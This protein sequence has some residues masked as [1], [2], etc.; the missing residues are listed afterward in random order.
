LAE[1]THNGVW[2]DAMCPKM[3]PVDVTNYGKKDRNFH[4]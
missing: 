4:A 3:R 1:T 2:I